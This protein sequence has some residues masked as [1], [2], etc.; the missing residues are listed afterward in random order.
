MK[1]I[2]KN[3]ITSIIGWLFM[4]TAIA[5]IFLVPTYTITLIVTLVGI[6]LGL[7]FYKS[8]LYEALIGKIS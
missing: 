6:G 5:V 7:V 8:K 2:T 3:L 4:L 1:M